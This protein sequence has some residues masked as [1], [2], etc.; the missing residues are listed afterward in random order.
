MLQD[1]ENIKKFK[2]FRNV[3]FGGPFLDRKVLFSMKSLR[4]LQLLILTHVHNIFTFTFCFYKCYV[5]KIVQLT[6]A[7]F[8]TF[9]QIF[10]S[11]FCK[12]S[13][14]FIYEII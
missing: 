4:N 2:F 6:T 10:F 1:K 5:K 11:R 3:V 13:F 9:F 12:N 8:A 14:W 7:V